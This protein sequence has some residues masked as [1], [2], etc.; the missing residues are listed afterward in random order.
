MINTASTGWS[1][2]TSTPF[3]FRI[4]PRVEVER[5]F[6]LS[7]LK[8]SSLLVLT[9]PGFAPSCTVI[10]SSLHWSI[11]SFSPPPPPLQLLTASPSSLL[12]LQEAGGRP[13]HDPSPLLAAPRSTDHSLLPSDGF[14][15]FDSFT[16]TLLQLPVPPSASH[17]P[18]N[19]SSLP[20]PPHISL[21]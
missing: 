18:P 11:S 10:T 7:L 1:T 13:A 8:A 17:W 14:S 4:L 5:S 15:S 12:R 2:P 9:S 3:S 16:S 20:S 21:A 6:A 19:I